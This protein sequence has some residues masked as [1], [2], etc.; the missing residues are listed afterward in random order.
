MRYI[1]VADD[2]TGASDTLAT[3]RRAGLKARLYLAAPSCEEVADLDAFG[4][5]TAARSM[6]QQT[7]AT[8]MQCIGHQLLPHQPDILHLKVCSTFDS[9]LGTG[10]IAT[11]ITALSTQLKP[12]TT[13]IVGGQPSLGRYCVFGNLFAKSADEQIYRIDRHPVMQQHP[14][15]P[16]QEADLR[17]H[18]SAMGLT[19]IN[20]LDRITLHNDDATP[21]TPVL[22]DALD[23]HDLKRIG[24]RFRHALKPQLWVGASSVVEALYPTPQAIEPPSSLPGPLLV[25]AGSRSSVT[26]AQVAATSSMV[27]VTI[28][29]R[30]LANQSHAEYEQIL[31]HLREG[32]ATLAV[33][34]E[35][36][37]HGLTALEIAQHSAKLIASLIR[38]NSI[39]TLLIAGG[40]TSSLAIHHL[41]PQSIDYIGPLEAGV[42]VCAANFANGYQLPVIMK[43]GQ[44]GSV[45]LFDKVCVLTCRND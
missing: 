2:F 10:N 9:S 26:A 38:S 22:C 13:L 40:D 5:A 16:M 45:T 4:I 32:K 6:D 23:N 35:D 29:T 33:L 41:Q 42:P 39:G 15:T 12:A 37:T 36:T 25:F 14:V 43:G 17:Q 21:S 3:L 7:L 24:E 19:N 30:Q 18:F 27:K 34:D 20:L 11:S 44:M 28:S 31:R 1:F 8:E